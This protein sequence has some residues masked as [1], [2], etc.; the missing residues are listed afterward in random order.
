MNAQRRHDESGWNDIFNTFP[1]FGEDIHI[2]F[3]P[4]QPYLLPN[5]FY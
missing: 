2:M 5:V 3:H 1:Y 4:C